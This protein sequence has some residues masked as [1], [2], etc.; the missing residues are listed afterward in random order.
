LTGIRNP[1][2]SGV[3][4]A[5]SLATTPA[6]AQPA[7]NTGTV[8]GITLNP[9]TLPNSNVMPASF[10][11]GATGNVTVGFDTN[12]PWPFDGTIRIDFPAGFDVS[13]ATFVTASGPNGAFSSSVSGQTVTV[14][15]N[16]GGST[17]QGTGVS[18]VLGPIQN[19]AAG[20]TGDF[21]LTLAAGGGAAID[22][23]TVP[24]VTLTP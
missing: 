9:G 5:F 12:N 23:G 4:G 20:T 19:P 1:P 3:T 2:V 24:G 17:F 16:G 18:L 21:T 15:R 14:T 13:G 11:A 6:F 10:T 22:I 8:P 7:I